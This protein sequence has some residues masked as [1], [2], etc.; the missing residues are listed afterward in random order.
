[1]SR[2]VERFMN[3]IWLTDYIRNLIYAE[4][5]SIEKSKDLIEI[6]DWCKYKNVQ[7]II[8]LNNKHINRAIKE[9][10]QNERLVKILK[11]ETNIDI[12]DFEKI[13]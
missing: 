12:I 10:L 9:V 4:N 3:L 5:N 2:D 8:D 7:E 11:E 6:L 13:L 1:M